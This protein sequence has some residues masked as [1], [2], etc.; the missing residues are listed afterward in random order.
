[1]SRCDPSSARYVG[2]GCPN[3]WVLE[4]ATLGQVT[5]FQTTNDLLEKSDVDSALQ[6]AWDNSDSIYVELYERKVQQA[7]AGGVLPSGLTL[8]QWTERFH[9][10]RR[11]TF[12]PNSRSIPAHTSPHLHAHE[13]DWRSAGFAGPGRPARP[14]HRAA[15]Y[16]R[17]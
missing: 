11:V 16:V 10:R 15:D 17:P 12:P 3:R 1:M 6:N 5:G 2:S 4:Q 8:G 9:E 14:R 7:D 13:H